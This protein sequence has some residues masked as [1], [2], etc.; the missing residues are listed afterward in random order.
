MTD[1]FDLSLKAI[2]LVETRNGIE[3]IA[4]AYCVAEAMKEERRKVAEE[5]LTRANVPDDEKAR[6]VAEMFS[7]TPTGDRLK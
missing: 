4:A 6:I 7:A 1:L 5:A 3:P 2:R